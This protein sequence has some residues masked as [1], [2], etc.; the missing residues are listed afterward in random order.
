MNGPYPSMLPFIGNVLWILGASGAL[1]TVSYGL[2]Y[3]TIHD[4]SLRYTFSTP[5]FLFPLC[6]GSMFLCSGVAMSGRFG[7]PRAAWL[8]TLVMVAGAVVFAGQSVMYY[9]AG[10]RIGWNTSTEG[11][12]RP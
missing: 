10:T 3:R 1:A 9:L 12:S 8:W 7:V 11:M 2:W 5:R 4:W 6:L